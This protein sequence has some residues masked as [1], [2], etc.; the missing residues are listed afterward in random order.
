M[1][2]GPGTVIG[3]AWLTFLLVWL[4]SSFWAKRIAKRERGTPIVGRVLLGLLAYFLLVPARHEHLSILATEVIPETLLQAWLG[5]A[6][7]CAGVAFAIWARVHI[8]SYWSATVALK[9]D[10]QLIRSGPYARIRHP[11]YT[12]VLLAIAGSAVASDTYGGLLAVA[13]YT[14]GFWV[15]ARKE[16]ALLAG[17][18]GPA[19]EEHRRQT[20]FLLPR[21]F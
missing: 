10:H 18:F 20:G 3:I 15:K 12:G 11:I 17:E 19:F 7:T 4:V 1:N 8:G 9:A 13:I 5:A 6:M 2:I 16:E 21:L 14:V